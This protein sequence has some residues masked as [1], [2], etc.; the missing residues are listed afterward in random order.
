M[1]EICNRLMGHLAVP[2]ASGARTF[3]AI[4]CNRPEGHENCRSRPDCEFNDRASGLQV[5]RTAAPSISVDKR[6]C[7]VMAES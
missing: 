6:G 2:G 1:N 5:V 3:L 7:V 4:R